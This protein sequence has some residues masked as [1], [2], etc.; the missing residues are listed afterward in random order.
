M[1]SAKFTFLIQR[2]EK[3]IL[4]NKNYVVIQANINIAW[5][6][7]MEIIKQNIVH[8]SL[9]YGILEIA[10]NFRMKTI[11]DVACWIINSCFAGYFF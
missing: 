2:H 1:I 10:V 3:I 8:T 7:F 5:W 6:Y 4:L 11:S 9:E